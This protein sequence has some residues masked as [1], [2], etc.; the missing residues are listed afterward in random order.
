M[1]QILPSPTL[2]EDLWF[3]SNTKHF[4]ISNCFIFCLS[5]S[6]FQE[7]LVWHISWKCI[8]RGYSIDFINEEMEFKDHF[9]Q[10]RILL[11]MFWKLGIYRNCEFPN[12]SISY[13]G[14]NIKIP[15]VY[16]YS[17]ESIRIRIPNVRSFH[18]NIMFCL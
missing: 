8:S 12:S 3:G 11:E 7:V 2:N 18:C 4:S 5:I 14:H 1:L 15:V 10:K 9:F 16:V 17:N 6:S 13:F